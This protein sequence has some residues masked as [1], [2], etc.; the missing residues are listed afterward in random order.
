MNAPYVENPMAIRHPVDT[1][2]QS[3]LCRAA[4]GARFMAA[5]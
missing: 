2:F 3:M 4:S 5:F 1:A